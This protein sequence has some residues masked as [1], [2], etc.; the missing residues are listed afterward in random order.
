MS[1]LKYKTD[2]NN[3]LNKL[4]ILLNKMMRQQMTVK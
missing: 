4:Q 1:V 2:K 3:G